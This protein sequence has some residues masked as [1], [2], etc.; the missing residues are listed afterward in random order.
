[1]NGR[2]NSMPEKK[3]MKLKCVRFNMRW[4]LVR[5]TGANAALV[6]EPLALTFEGA[7][8]GSEADFADAIADGRVSGSET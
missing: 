7:E 8:A 6:A 1:M 5:L 2:E 3:R 4:L